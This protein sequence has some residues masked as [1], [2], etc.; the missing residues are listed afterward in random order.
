MIA[1]MAVAIA[2]ATVANGF[3]VIVAINILERIRAQ[4]QLQTQLQAAILKLMTDG[5]SKDL[6]AALTTA[7]QTLS[8][9]QDFD[10]RVAATLQHAMRSAPRH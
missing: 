6:D 3:L 5:A 4:A 7:K 2:A 8:D 10:R 1:I 9:I